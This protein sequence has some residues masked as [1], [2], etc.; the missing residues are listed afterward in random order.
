MECILNKKPTRHMPH[1]AV[2]EERVIAIKVKTKK[3]ARSGLSWTPEV[4]EF[5][6]DMY[7]ELIES[8]F[9]FHEQMK[10]LSLE[11]LL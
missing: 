10:E 2:P 6:M 5:Y 9:P 8:G 3:S 7:P 11:D 4:A 1:K